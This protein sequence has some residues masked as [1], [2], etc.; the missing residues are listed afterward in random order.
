MSDDLQLVVFT[1][2]GRR[3]GLELSSVERVFPMVAVSPLPQ[4]P[5]IALGIVNVH[6]RIVP[7]VDVRRRFG[8]PGRDY[9]LSTQLL[10]ARTAR[11]VL[12]L[13][14]DEVIGIERQAG[15][16]VVPTETLLPSIEHVTRQ[17]LKGVIPLADDLLFLHD[18]EAFLSLEEE[19]ELDGA[20]REVADAAVA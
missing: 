3:Y 8:L 11:R 7:V 18:L 9:G 19:H 13:P 6:G 14:V 12:A 17:H 20:L 1:L 4:G 5:A 10:V 2:D 15:G 16:S